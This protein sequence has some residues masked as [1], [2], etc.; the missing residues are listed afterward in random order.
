MVSDYTQFKIDDVM[1]NKLIFLTLLLS[2][3]YSCNTRSFIK[4]YT[5]TKDG[6]FPKFSKKEY[7]AGQVE[8]S[9]VDGLQF[10]VKKWL[11]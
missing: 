6:K 3:L 2:V 9:T 10:T 8:Q 1:K 7:L 11:G 5:T 4:Y